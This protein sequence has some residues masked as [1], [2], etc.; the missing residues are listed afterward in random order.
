MALCP[1]LFF[2][3][4]ERKTFGFQ[5]ALGTGYTFYGDSNLSHNMNKMMDRGYGRLILYAD[6]GIT[7]KATD[8]L[9]FL[10]GFQVMGDMAWNSGAYSNHASP[11]F[12]GGLQFY[13]GISNLSF[14]LA[15]ALG[16]RRDW[17]V[18][19]ADYRQVPAAKWGNGF[20]LA[21]EYDF[22]SG[23]GIVPGAGL[24]YLFMPTGWD[25]Y[26]NTLAVYFRLAFR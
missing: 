12:F 16:F 14:S 25:N 6:T 9:Y 10:A 15:Y 18:L 22:K 26:D 24:C 13:P 2:A 21:A 23:G 7:L 1:S 11:A 4:Q 20:R 3:E 19:S 5:F 8:F 17:D